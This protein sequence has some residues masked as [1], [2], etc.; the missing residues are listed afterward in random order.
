MTEVQMS[1]GNQTRENKEMLV[2]LAI[3]WLSAVCWKILIKRVHLS[4]L[5]TKETMGKNRRGEREQGTRAS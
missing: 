2:M 3:S 1:V 4:M 5:M